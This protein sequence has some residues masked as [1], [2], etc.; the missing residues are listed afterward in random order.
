MEVTYLGG[1]RAGL[2]PPDDPFVRLAARTAEQ[3]YGKPAILNPLTGGSG[4][5][6]AFRTHL[7]TPIITLGPGD[8]DL[9]AHAPNESLSLARFTQGTK[10][11]AHLL[12]AYGAA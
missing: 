11:M 9:A 8:E 6:Y 2:T 3:V 1:E 10:H 5:T 12:L 7:G 4:P